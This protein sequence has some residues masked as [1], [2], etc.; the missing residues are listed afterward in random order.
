MSV[1]RPIV[2]DFET[3]GIES[4]PEYPPVPVGFSIK[5]PSDKKAVYHAWGHSEGNNCDYKNAKRLL[6]QAWCSGEPLLFHNSKFDYD[7]AT[8]HMGCPALPWERIHDT[9]YLLFLYDPHA[10]SLALK[11]AAEALLGLPPEER[12]VVHEWIKKNIKLGKGERWG[13][14]I[15]DAPGGLVGSY[16][17]GDVTRTEKL[18]TH[19]Y[20]IIEKDGMLGAY[21]RERKLM[22]IFLENERRG[23]R[24]DTKA[25]KRDIPLYQKAKEDAEGWLRKQLNAP[26]MNIDSDAEM[27]EALS[28]AGVVTEWSLTKTGRK[29]VSKQNM[30][31]D[32]F[33]DKQV[34]YVLGYRNRL[35]TCLSMFM[36]TWLEKAQKTGGYINPN[37]NQVRQS[38]DGGSSKGTR[39]GRPSC[40]DPNLLNL[41]K[42][43]EN[44]GD[45]YTHPTFFTDKTLPLVRRYLLPDEGELWGHRDFNQQ[46]LR[47]LAHF[48]NDAILKAYVENPDLD[49]HTFVQ[50][51]IKRLMHRDLDRV[52]V[53]T[54]NFGKLYGQGLNS[55][56]KKLGVT[57][58][59]V[60]DIRNSQDRALP[61]LKELE[62]NI[63]R[64]AKAGNP[65]VTW[66]GRLYYCEEPEYVEKFG[67]E[68][69]FEYKLINYLVQGS[70]ADATKE[71]IIRYNSARK[72]GRFLVTVY[73]ENN[74]SCRADK[75]AKEMKIMRECMEGLEFDVPMLTDAKV[76]KNWGTLTT[77]KDT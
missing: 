26:D 74:F 75:M 15:A 35:N 72:A 51:E 25:L 64:W 53:K 69:T 27:A 23:L 63:K 65:I 22:P 41:S 77:Y 58:D 60:R 34:F 9:L 21:N 5:R 56:A 7:V 11:P 24:V 39:T 46:E 59:E 42:D 38:K 8:T 18:F 14:R 43:F 54:M 13:S 3:R 49:I 44:R 36:E 47:V 45:G 68:M 50:S 73:D 48:E 37:W 6:R 28:R 66:G 30:T 32:T 31:I 55:L 2:I 61:G 19:L 20:P 4:R 52:S 33:K 10:P 67:R 17:N 12:D 62:E 29:S 70:A 1:P 76:G 71:A 57:V 40:D 16:A